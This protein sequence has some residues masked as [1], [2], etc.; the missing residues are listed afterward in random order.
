MDSAPTGHGCPMLSLMPSRGWH[1]LLFPFGMLLNPTNWGPFSSSTFWG[2]IS[3]TRVLFSGL[4]S[5]PVS[6][7]SAACLR[8]LYTAPKCILNS[9]EVGHF[10]RALKPF[11]L[12]AVRQ[13]KSLLH[14]IVSALSLH[15]DFLW[16]IKQRFISPL[17]VFLCC[18]Q[19]WISDLS[20]IGL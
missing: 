6:L 12:S 7:R 15:S 9:L 2:M 18:H 20:L 19:A 3:E 16:E 1:Q 13:R 8:I 4:I 5:L 17:Q 10:C 14:C 11:S